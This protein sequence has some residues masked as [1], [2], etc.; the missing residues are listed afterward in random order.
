MIAVNFFFFF[1]FTSVLVQKFFKLFW[2]AFIYTEA[3][4]REDGNVLGVRRMSQKQGCR[5]PGGYI[6]PNNMAVS[7]PIVWVWSSSASSPI[8]WLWC[9]SVGVHVNSGKNCSTFG[10]DLFFLVFTWIRGKKWFIFGE[11]LFFGLHLI[12][13]PEENCGRG[14]K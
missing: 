3:N 12:C 8:I 7:P 11:D 13:S 10:E 4:F 6:P 5:N 14:W 9:V 1:F 2:K